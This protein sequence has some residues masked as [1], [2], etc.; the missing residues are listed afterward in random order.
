MNCARIIVFFIGTAGMGLAQTTFTLDQAVY[1][2]GQDIVSSWTGGPGSA[3][4]WVG[5][6]PRGTVPDGDPGHY[7]RIYVN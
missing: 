7:I 5:R 3:N 4:D 2:P 1:A 6:Y